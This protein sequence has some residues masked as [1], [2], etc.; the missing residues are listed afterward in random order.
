MSIM[1]GNLNVSQI[2]K[3]LGIDFPDE[4]REFMKNTHQ[5]SASNVVSGKWHCFDIPFTIVCGDMETAKK[6]FDSVSNRA[7]EVKEALEF[8]IR[9][10]K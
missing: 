3:R 5:D 8:S 10:V 7:S 6:I 9:E 4:I 1:L 2:E